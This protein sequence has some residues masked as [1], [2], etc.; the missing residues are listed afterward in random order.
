MQH[1]EAYHALELQRATLQS[2]AQARLMV[3]RI[4]VEN[5]LLDGERA[6]LEAEL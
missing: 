1:C 2:N 5:A 3:N 6:R 4:D